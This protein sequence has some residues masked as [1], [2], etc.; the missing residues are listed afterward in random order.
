MLMLRNIHR[1]TAEPAPAGSD[2]W[3]QPN[4]FGVKRLETVDVLVEGALR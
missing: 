3:C 4:A 1:L 2:Y